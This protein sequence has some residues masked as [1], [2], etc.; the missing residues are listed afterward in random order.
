MGD[1]KCGLLL[2]DGK[3]MMREYLWKMLEKEKHQVHRAAGHKGGTDGGLR[4]QLING[5][6]LCVGKGVQGLEGWY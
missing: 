5:G 2:A 1:L 4:M 6:T 3:K